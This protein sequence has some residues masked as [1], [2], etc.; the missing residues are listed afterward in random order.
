MSYTL[1]QLTVHVFIS[2]NIKTGAQCVALQFTMATSQG[3]RHFFFF[4]SKVILWNHDCPMFIV[5]KTLCNSWLYFI[6]CSSL[7]SHIPFSFPWIALNLIFYSYTHLSYHILNVT[8]AKSILYIYPFNHSIILIFI[9]IICHICQY[10]FI[11]LWKM[12]LIE[13]KL[14]KISIM[15]FYLPIFTYT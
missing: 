8:Y 15:Q 7:S 9:W 10:E 4:S 6:S 13:R 3:D 5:H 11:L 12:S 1:T 2:T 14:R